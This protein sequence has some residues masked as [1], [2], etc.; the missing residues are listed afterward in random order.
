MLPASQSVHA[1]AAV[2]RVRQ[3][4]DH[5]RGLQPRRHHRAALQG[6]RPHELPGDRSP[7]EV[8]RHEYEYRLSSLPKKYFALEI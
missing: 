8:R 4:G 3:R 5:E 7:R 6:L 1:G 2:P